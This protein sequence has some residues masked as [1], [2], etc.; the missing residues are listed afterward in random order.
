MDRH[1]RRGKSSGAL[2]DS[3]ISQR[4]ADMESAVLSLAIT[5]ML[6]VLYTIT[7]S[8]PVTEVQY[9]T[10]ALQV[11]DRSFLLGGNASFIAIAFPRCHFGKIFGLDL[12]IAAIVNLLQYACFALLQGPLQHDPLY[13]NIGF[14]ILVSLACIHPI[15][16][17]LYCRQEKQKKSE[18]MTSLGAVAVPEK[19]DE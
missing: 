1:K 3:P 7:A 12:A 16:V 6:C 8:I 13:L 15:N 9:L 19:Q 2:S 4:L 11:I 18:L 5:V 17:Y 10:F 14:I